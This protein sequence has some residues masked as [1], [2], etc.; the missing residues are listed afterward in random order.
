MIDSKPT[1]ILRVSQVPLHLYQI[2]AGFMLLNKKGIIDL[3]LE[4]SKVLLPYNMM[5]LEIDNKIKVLYDVNDGYDNLLEEGKNY[6]D[7]MDSI[8]N[9]YDICFK[10]SYSKNYNLPLSNGYKVNPLGLNY[11]TTIKGNLAH[12]SYKDDPKNEKIKKFIRRLPFSQ[13]YNN[14]Y[15]IENFENKPKLNNEPK[16]LFFARLWDPNGVELRKLPKEK[17]EERIEINKVRVECIKA[18]KKEFGRYFDGGIT[19]SNYSNE[20]YKELVVNNKKITNRD[21]YLKLMKESDICIATTG[22]HDSIGWKFGEYVAASKAIVSEKLHYELPGDFKKEKNYLEFNNVDK[23]INSI[24]ELIQD[25][26]K[27]YN[28]MKNNHIYYMNYVKPDKLVFNSL[29]ICFEKLN[30]ENSERIYL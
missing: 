19:Q 20:N 26:N 15:L 3:K 23:C 2:I 17:I 5:E 7:F 21:G 1:C 25:K 4:E 12:K 13:Y 30:D 11:M 10:R 27:R 6:V 16:I 24:Y 14:K 18:C 9:R 29:R 22:L 8:L 28:M